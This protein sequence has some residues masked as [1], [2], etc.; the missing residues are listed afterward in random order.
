MPNKKKT[1]TTA[2]ASLSAIASSFPSYLDNREIIPSKIYALDKSLINGGFEMGLTYQFVGEPG[3]GKS[4][5]NL[6]L[7]L[8]F[9]RQGKKVLYVDSE[10]VDN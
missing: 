10:R 2:T 4:T 7:A 9:C 3:T 6:F 1:D 5:L 8:N